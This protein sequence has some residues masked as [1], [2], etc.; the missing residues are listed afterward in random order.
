MKDQIRILGID[1]SPFR[2]GGGKAL[3]VGAVMRAPSYLEGLMRTMVT[4]DGR[5]STER[6]VEMVSGSRYCE[7]VKAVMLDGIAL[8]GFN[9][10]DIESLHSS[11]GIPVL[12]VTR[13]EPDLDDIKRALRKHFDDWEERYELISRFE[14]RRVDTPHKPLFACG[15]GLAWSDFER[16]IRLSTVRGV[17][18]E[19]LRVAHL[20]A[21]AMVKGESRGRS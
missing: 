1:D 4:I 21:A 7:Q 13:D 17:V 18:P 14:L 12:T 8:G 6:L 2:F 3:V 9:V 20:V 10:V 11:L 19:P 5:D 16:I 15:V